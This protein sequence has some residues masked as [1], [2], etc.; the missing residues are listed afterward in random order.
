MVGKQG[1]GGIGNVCWGHMM[2]SLESWGNVYLF[3]SNRDF[4][5]I[6]G[7]LDFINQLNFRKINLEL[8]WTS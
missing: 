7:S 8:K 5:E 2:E 4:L 3:S 1:F 6:F